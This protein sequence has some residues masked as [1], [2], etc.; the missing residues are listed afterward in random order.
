[1][2]KTGSKVWYAFSPVSGRL[3]RIKMDNFPVLSLQES[4]NKA[5]ARLKDAHLGLLTETVVKAAAT[6]QA[7]LGEIILHFVDH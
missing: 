7:T 3:K 6:K 5:K 4:H 1:V 2:S